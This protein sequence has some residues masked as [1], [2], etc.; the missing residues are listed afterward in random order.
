[1]AIST[2]RYLLQQGYKPEDI[3]VLTPYLGQL[4][5][6]R[7]NLQKAMSLE[8]RD[9]GKVAPQARYDEVPGREGRET[10][11]EAWCSRGGNDSQM[12]LCLLLL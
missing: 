2:V 3:V 10:E 4:V 12:T 6:I 11:E 5:E 8:V 9:V 1:M 7:R